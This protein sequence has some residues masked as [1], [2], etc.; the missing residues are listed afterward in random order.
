MAG[1][2]ETH[3]GR[4]TAADVAEPGSHDHWENCWRAVPGLMR[5]QSSQQRDWIRQ[6]E[7][8]RVRGGTGTAAGTDGHLHRACLTHKGV[9]LRCATESKV[10]NR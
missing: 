7:S 8:D 5:I 4:T 1:P 6:F 3:A 10:N 2:E 9:A